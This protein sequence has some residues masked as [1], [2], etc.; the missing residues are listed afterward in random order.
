MPVP[1]CLL[2]PRAPV[3]GV[4][5]VPGPSYRPDIRSVGAHHEN[6]G[7][8]RALR[9][10][11]SDD[12]REDDRLAIRRVRPSHE[13]GHAAE[14]GQLTEVRAV[15]TDGEE[16]PTAGRPSGEKDPGSVGR[17]VGMFSRPEPE[18]RDAA[19]PASVGVGDVDRRPVPGFPRKSELF[20]VGRPAGLPAGAH[21]MRVPKV[22]VGHPDTVRLRTS[23]PDEGDVSAVRRVDRTR[24]VGTLRWRRTVRTGGTEPPETSSVGPNRPDVTRQTPLEDDARA[25]GRPVRLTV[26]RSAGDVCHLPLA[27]A[28]AVHDE[29]LRLV[30]SVVQAVPLE[31][32]TAVRARRG[33][34]GERCHEARAGRGQANDQKCFG[35]VHA[36]LPRSS[37][38]CGYK[39]EEG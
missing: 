21:T 39:T 18:R 38:P 9:V 20:P 35:S 8:A 26:F 22:C 19:A 13:F 29:D 33:G 1:L 10:D 6:V 32:D 2:R 34:V 17:P 28:V 37:V 16:V 27:A 31:R 4:V 5:V 23:K 36:F 15:R 24:V 3:R 30:R 14:V 12:R 7:Q 25:V 11:R